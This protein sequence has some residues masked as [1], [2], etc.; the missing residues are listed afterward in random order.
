MS[1]ERLGTD[2]QPWFAR[3]QTVHGIYISGIAAVSSLSDSESYGSIDN[4]FKVSLL[5]NVLYQAVHEAD[6]TTHLDTENKVGSLIALHDRVV[7]AGTFL[8]L[9]SSSSAFRSFLNKELGCLLES[10]CQQEVCL[11]AAEFLSR[12]GPYL[13]SD[14]SVYGQDL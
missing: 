2:L 1:L 6:L 4:C 8:L 5:L 11:R 3:V 12:G 13:G 14:V 10:C 7:S 9:S